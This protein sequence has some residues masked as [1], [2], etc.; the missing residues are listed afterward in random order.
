[1]LA[2]GHLVPGT[3]ELRRFGVPTD[4]P[5]RPLT[6]CGV[7]RALVGYDHD[8]HLRIGSLGQAELVAAAVERIDAGPF[9]R[10]FRLEER[11][12]TLEHLLQVE[13]PEVEHR[14]DGDVRP[15]AAD[16]ARHS[17]H[18]PEPSLESV[19]RVAVDEVRL[20]ENEDVR[21]RDLLRALVAAAE[22]LLDVGRVDERNDPVE[23]ELRAISSSMKK[24][25][26]TGP[27][28]ASPVVSTST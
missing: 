3:N 11:G 7:V 1:M 21:E 5:L 18:V 19:E 13:G 16:D 17:V 10:V 4:T 2:D 24:V 22:L 26:A 12:P 20:V 25:W 28:S 23:R 14:I 9:E 6:K 27:G 8:R 15:L